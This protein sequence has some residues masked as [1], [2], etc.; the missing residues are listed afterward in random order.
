MADLCVF[1]Q[2]ETRPLDSTRETEVWK[3]RCN[4]V[5]RRRVGIALQQGQ[6]LLDFDKRARPCIALDTIKA[7]ASIIRNAYSHDRIKEGLRFLVDLADIGNELP[8]G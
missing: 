7:F 2:V 4:Y 1:L 8:K 3:R 6:N 5:K